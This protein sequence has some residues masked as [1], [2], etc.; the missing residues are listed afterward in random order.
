MSD[1]DLFRQ[2]YWRSED[3]RSNHVDVP[4]YGLQFG[5]KYP[6]IDTLGDP[7]GEML[8][9]QWFIEKQKEY[10]SKNKPKLLSLSYGE[11]IRPVDRFLVSLINEMN[12]DA[13]YFKDRPIIIDK[14]TGHE[15]IEQDNGMFWAV[16]REPVNLLND[17][18][19]NVA[20]TIDL[21]NRDEILIDTFSKLLPLWR[22]ELNIPEPS[23]PVTGGWESIRKKIIEYKI[24]PMIDLLSWERTTKNRISLG[25]LAVALFPDGEKDSIM[26]A[27]TVKP[28]LDKLMTYDSLEK[29]RKE[30][31]K[32]N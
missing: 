29:I 28:F 24:I 26:I 14:E 9:E 19:D 32:D 25:V 5:A 6:M 8:E 13:G 20:I 4:D 11:G 1:K 23:K 7:F 21:D 22:R 31:S 3:L 15:L 27:Q 17:A 12:A 2:L 10:S 18:I 30:L 16:M